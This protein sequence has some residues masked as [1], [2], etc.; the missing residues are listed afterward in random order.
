MKD[1]MDKCLRTGKSF[2]EALFCLQNTPQS[3]E[4]MSPAKFLY[5]RIVKNP[6]LLQPDDGRV[7][8]A[9]GEVK[10]QEKV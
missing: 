8:E 1:L 2:E 7:E 3:A 4:Q 6:E 10:L 5:W 9:G